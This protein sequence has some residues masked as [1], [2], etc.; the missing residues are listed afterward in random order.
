MSE[1]AP[2]P[3][4]TQDTP[5]WLGPIPRRP[6]PSIR[7]VQG[8]DV[9]V[10]RRRA[11]PASPF[12]VLR[13]LARWIAA[14]LR[15]ETLVLF[16]RLRGH[17]G[18]AGRAVRLRRTLEAMGGTAIK[19]GQQLSI[20]IDLL[21]GEFCDELSKMLDNVPPF[22][23]AEARTAIER[24]VGRPLEEVFAQIDPTPI[25]SA[26]V[27]CVFRGT[28][29]DGQD[30]AIKVRRP[31]ISEAFNADLTAIDWL[32]V[33][34]ETLTLVRPG[35]VRH[36]RTELRTMFMEELDFISEAR[37]QTIFRKE[38]RRD[39][40]R[41]VSAPRVHH[42][43]SNDEVMVSEF[44][45]GTPMTMVL[46]LHESGSVAD[47]AELDR[48]G[49]DPVVVGNQIIEVS[50]WG[51]FE[52]PVFHGDPHPANM[53]VSSDQR[54]VFIDFGAC[55]SIPARIRKVMMETNNRALANDVAGLVQVQ[56]QLLTPLPHIDVRALTRTLEGIFWNRL[57]SLRDA[58]APWWKRTTA[59]GF[60]DLM[61]AARSFNLP[62]NMD[63]V[64]VLRCS[65]L[66]DTV[67]ARLNPG[68]TLDDFRRYLKT[69]Q[70]R[71]DRR[72]RKIVRRDLGDRQVLDQVRELGD[73]AAQAAGQVEV[74][75]LSLPKEFQSLINKKSYALMVTL[76][77]VANLAL[78]AGLVA[79]S[80]AVRNW[81]AGG[82]T[83]MVE[84]ARAVVALP[85]FRLVAIALL[86]FALRRILFRVK[87]VAPSR[88]GGLRAG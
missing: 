22:P 70:K 41:F 64:R 75:T 52:C 49:I 81:M 84:A 26:S 76:R 69:Y 62:V 23:F 46:A 72:A 73:T 20:R 2:D 57:M 44:V 79:A 67:A 77:L 45:S 80:V 40:L 28:L 78:V 42:R 50:W 6:R 82:K 24:A 48:R 36:L 83:T 13:R 15:Y 85:A 7:D 87:D 16:D 30:V 17:G 31:G 8:P 43:L 3:M 4:G 58:D 39:K 51:T 71:A 86:L 61:K 74:A 34:A 38:A 56:L 11:L 12:R 35:F 63:T 47:R 10:L 14:G 18:D 9:V 29:R 37:Y 19:F 59:S 21:P 88:R 32:L 1:R 68:G 27:A 66:Y 60:I 65:L 33:L 5:A 25:G 54:L 55:G 53:I